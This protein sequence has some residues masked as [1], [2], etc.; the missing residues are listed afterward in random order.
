VGLQVLLPCLQNPFTGT[1][2]VQDETGTRLLFTRSCHLTLF[3][4]R[5]NQ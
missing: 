3:C 4:V 5:W 1:Y 2:A